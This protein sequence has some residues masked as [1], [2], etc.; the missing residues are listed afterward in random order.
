MSKITFYTSQYINKNHQQ[1]PKL[2]SSA[3]VPSFKNY[4]YIPVEKTTISSCKS[5]QNSRKGKFWSIF[6]E[7]ILLIDEKAIKIN[8]LSIC[9]HNSRSSM[10]KIL[11]LV[12]QLISFAFG[13]NSLCHDDILDMELKRKKK[14]K[15][16]S[17]G[18]TKLSI[19]GE[20]LSK[21]ITKN[22]SFS[23]AIVLPS[24]GYYFEIFRKSCNISWI[25]NIL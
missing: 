1:I 8:L 10:C 25:N 14:C 19:N 9:G 5:C 18:K 12:H 24:L 21:S 22:T 16:Y 6:E 13:K 23:I 15:Y 3:Y 2:Y 20:Q 17:C 7:D 11:S 4:R